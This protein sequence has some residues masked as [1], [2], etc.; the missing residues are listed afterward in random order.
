MVE[1]G[2]GVREELDMFQYHSAIVY[3]R[4]R[5]EK[6]TSEVGNPCVLHTLKF[7]NLCSLVI[8]LNTAMC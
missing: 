2:G 1:G 8:L 4:C 7:I 3:V 6:S 5:E